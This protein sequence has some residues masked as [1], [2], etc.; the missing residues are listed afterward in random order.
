[1]TF[2]GFFCFFELMKVQKKKYSITIIN[3]DGSA[4]KFRGLERSS[5]RNIGRLWKKGDRYLN[6]YSKQKVFITRCLVDTPNK[7]F[8]VDAFL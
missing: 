5:F 3:S 7:T 6:V 2:Q 1:M 4:R 8:K